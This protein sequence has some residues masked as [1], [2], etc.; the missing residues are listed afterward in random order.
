M[1]K[2]ALQAYR[3]AVINNFNFFKSA[4]NI[5]DAYLRAIEIEGGGFLLPVAKLHKNDEMLLQQL[6]DWRN[7]HVKVYPTQFVATLESTRSWLEDRLL[8]VPDRML[9]LVVTP[10]GKVVGHL[11]FNSCLN[12]DFQFEIDNV[13][14]GIPSESPGIFA[15]AMV[16]IIEWARKTLN[17]S[18]FFLKVFDDNLHALAFYRRCGFIEENRNPLLRECKGDM[19]IYREARP[20]ESKDKDFIC[21]RYKPFRESGT[22]MILTAGPSISALETVYAFDAAKN[23][24]NSQWSKYLNR[25]EKGFAEYVGAKYALATSSCTGALQIALMSLGVGPGDEVIV[26]DLTWVASANAVRYVGA[27]PVFADVEPDTWNIDAHSIEDLITPNTKA[28]IAVH[29]YGHPARMDKVM[30]VARRNNLKVVE[31]AAPSIGAEWQGQRCGSI[32]DFA[33]FSFQG[34]KLLVTG[35]GGMLVTNNDDLYQKALKIWDQGRNPTKAFWIDGHGVKFKMSNIQA[36]LGL[37]QLE[38]ADE[39]IEMK[40]RIF[41]WYKEGLADAPFIKLNKEVEGARSIYW[42]SSLILDESSPLSRDQLIKELKNKNIDTRPVFPAISQ[43]PIWPHI[44]GPQ[45]NAVRIGS[46]GVN[47]PSGVCLLRD[48]VRYVCG[49]I[50]EILGGY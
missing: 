16:A 13:V 47:L 39:Q 20:G 8:A 9:F 4:A 30:E 18:G 22:T 32:G 19:V 40:R 44:Q 33:A 28:I 42:M 46:H 27:M 45:K 36:A 34:A 37:A 1:D 25:F 17:V 41:D 15:R 21:L 2:H 31:D 50:R 43:Y 26:P 49:A 14:R 48:E 35:E 24:W 29:L 12:D 10:I 7:A 11:G 5:Q 6:T 3:K 23:G 38:R